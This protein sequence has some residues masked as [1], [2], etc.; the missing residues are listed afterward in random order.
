M[1]RHSKQAIRGTNGMRHEI[2]V[3]GAGLVGGVV[4]ADLA[5]SFSVVTFDQDPVTL[6]ILENRSPILKTSLLD[7]TDQNT[8]EDTMEAF[9]VVINALPGRLG[10][11]ILEQLV[12]MGRKVVDIAFFPED[13]TSLVPLAR[14]SGAVVVFDMGLA[15]GMS[16]VLAGHH[17]ATLERVDRYECRVGGLPVVRTY[18]WEYKAPFSP[19]DVVEEYV[20]PAR[21]MQGGQLIV[22]PALSDRELVDVP[23]VGTL[24]A[25]NT[26]GLRSL[27]GSYKIPWMV[28]KTLR[29]PGH[30]D[31]VESLL[32]S[33]FFSSDPVAVNGTQVSPRSA[34]LRVLEQAWKLTPEDDE[35]TV[36]QVLVEGVSTA[37]GSERHTWNMLVRRDPTTGRSSMARAT[38][39]PC[40]AAVHCLVEGRLS[41]PG[42]YP[43][44]RLGERP[45]IF[46]FLLQYQEERGVRYRHSVEILS[47]R[48]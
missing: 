38:A 24:E 47:T 17:V 5:E 23:G 39:Y 42:V 15:P 20:R 44:E 34:T 48:G 8:L 22:K 19:E 12:A 25:F 26:D 40:N 3:L 10:Y 14:E 29:Y 30:A 33:G 7:V 37:G 9:P 43:P 2:A 46:S 11:R 28:E 21:L 31:L 35:L 36:L 27:L 41:Q 4:A 6:R 18:P 45:D 32:R 13:P 1:L 16:H